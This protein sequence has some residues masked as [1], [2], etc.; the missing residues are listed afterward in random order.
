MPK[1]RFD[2][3]LVDATTLTL[4]TAQ[5]K[6]WSLSYAQ[7]ADRLLAALHEAVHFVAM[8]EEGDIP[9]EVLIPMT[10][11]GR[12]HVPQVKGARSGM[13]PR[14]WWV[15][16]LGATFEV[17]ML[18]HGTDLPP[19]TTLAFWHDGA[20]AEKDASACGTE[21]VDAPRDALKQYYWLMRRWRL[22]DFAGTAF[23]L[24]SDA[25]G[26]VPRDVISALRDEVRE[27]LTSSW[28]GSNRSASPVA[29]RDAHGLL[30]TW[31]DQNRN[32][33]YEEWE[34]MPK[35]HEEYKAA[36]AAEQEE[37]FIRKMKKHGLWDGDI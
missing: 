18:N 33:T 28:D 36:R 30:D 31:R 32:V 8:V 25:H 12:S 29:F 21:L 5:N 2:P 22:V 3:T 15:T 37:K 26:Q 17:V 11:R 20:Q 23:L 13:Y 19:H 4:T 9:F 7:C 35:T 14:E 6:R 34:A 10:L 1:M 24:F 16:A 27:R